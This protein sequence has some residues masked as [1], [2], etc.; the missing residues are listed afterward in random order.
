[1]WPIFRPRKNANERGI[2]NKGIRA[3]QRENPHNILEKSKLRN[4]KSKLR[5]CLMKFIEKDIIFVMNKAII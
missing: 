2:S 5:T 4:E 1:M 3:S